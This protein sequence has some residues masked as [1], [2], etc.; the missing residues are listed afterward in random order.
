MFVHTLTFFHELRLRSIA[1]FKLVTN[2]VAERETNTIYMTSQCNV[3]R[4]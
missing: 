2:F 3:R 4:K 1:T